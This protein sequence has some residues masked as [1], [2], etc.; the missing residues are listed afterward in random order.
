[1]V[2]LVNKH[3]LEKEKGK[4]SGIVTQIVDNLELLLP[5]V[6]YEYHVW[7]EINH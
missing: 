1:M 2:I 7:K 4:K 6:L 5:T 3:N